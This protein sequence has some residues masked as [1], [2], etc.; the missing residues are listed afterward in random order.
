MNNPENNN[1]DNN[2]PEN[3]NPDSHNNGKGPYNKRNIFTNDKSD[4]DEEDREEA[5]SSTYIKENSS[6]Q[7]GEGIE[8]SY[9]YKH[10]KICKIYWKNILVD[11]KLKKQ[12][13]RTEYYDKKS[14]LYNSV[15]LKDGVE[16]AIYE[17]KKSNIYK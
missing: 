15:V 5:Y 17:H 2:N 7:Y 3:N 9:D 13:E 1:P 12:I 14:V 6:T 10:R 11:G 16:V 8:T 4:S